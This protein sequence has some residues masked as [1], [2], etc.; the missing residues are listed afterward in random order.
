M[1]ENENKSILKVKEKLFVR[2]LLE[3][4]SLWRA[5]S[6]MNVSYSWGR[7]IMKLLHRISKTENFIDLMFWLPQHP[8][9]YA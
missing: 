8:E 5:C 7:N 4:R 1:D 3:F 9:V 2:K 6:D